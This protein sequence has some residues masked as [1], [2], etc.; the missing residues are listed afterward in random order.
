MSRIDRAFEVWERQS[1][2]P[3]GERSA[4]HLGSEATKP[5]GLS[6]YAVEGADDH[7]Q[8]DRVAAASAALYSPSPVDVG[9]DETTRTQANVALRLHVSGDLMARLVTA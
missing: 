2:K 7:P 8:D 3:T 4:G 6:G 9:L 1:G 5:F